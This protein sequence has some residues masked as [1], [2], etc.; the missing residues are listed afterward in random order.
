M[1]ELAIATNLDAL[2]YYSVH[3]AG[4]KITCA[5]WVDAYTLDL[6]NYVAD[7]QEVLI[8]PDSTPPLYF[9]SAGA[10]KKTQVEFDAFIK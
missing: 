2:R 5:S 3:E 1:Y 6:Y 7:G 10:R 9:D 8:D 4:D